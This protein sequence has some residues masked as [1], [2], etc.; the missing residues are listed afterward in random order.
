MYKQR[1]I[2]HYADYYLD[3]ASP[4]SLCKWNQAAAS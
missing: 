2:E 3:T 1:E 4:R